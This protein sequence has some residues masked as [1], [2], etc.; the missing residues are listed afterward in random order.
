LSTEKG[1]LIPPD[2]SLLAVVLLD[3]PGKRRVALEPDYFGLRTASNQ[4]WVGYGLAAP[5]WHGEKPQ[6]AFF[7]NEQP[8]P[9][10]WKR[11]EKESMIEAACGFRN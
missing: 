2:A 8:F 9:E 1:Q 3:K 11:T 10:E 5:N 6:T 7:G 4:V